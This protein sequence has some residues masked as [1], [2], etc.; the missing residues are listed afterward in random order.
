MT[1]GPDDRRAAVTV[2]FDN[3]GEVS[4][5]KR[6]TWPEDKP[7]GRHF[8]V[9][10]ALPR[11]LALLEELDLRATFFVEGLN[12]ELYPDGLA[13]IAAARHEVAYHGWC[14]EQWAELDPS[15]EAELLQRGVEAMDGLGLRP[16]GFRPPG[17]RL[18][19]AS[20]SALGE[21]GF[22]YCSPAGQGVGVR[23]GIAIL[24]FEWRVLD[25]Y[26]Y[27]PRFG[28]LR[29]RDH[30][31]PD[32]LPPIRFAETLEGALKTDGHVSLVFH[33]F[34]TEPEERFE[35]IREALAAVRERAD[36]WCAPYRDLARWVGE[37][38]DELALDAT[39]A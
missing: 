37:V 23:E 33:P 3:L 11:I 13:E 6:G 35:V 31:S 27:L 18:T 10:R 30:G 2:S 26:H 21:V 32:P 25:A 14:H 17:G 38:E 24:P 20:L 7:V 5:I 9:T 29:E 1:W 36:L 22:T 28:P 16:A 8:S 4:D 39:P 15:R 19:S 34:L 12:T